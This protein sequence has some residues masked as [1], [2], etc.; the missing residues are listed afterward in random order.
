[1]R[2]ALVRYADRCPDDVDAV[3]LAR[4]IAASSPSAGR[5]I[6]IPWPLWQ[7]HG[8]NPAGR[9]LSMA[10]TFKLVAAV[11]ALAAVGWAIAGGPGPGPGPS[12]VDDPSPSPTSLVGEDWAFFSGTVTGEASSTD[13]DPGYED[14]GI[15]VTLGHGSQGDFL[16]TDDPRMNGT[17]TRTTNLFSQDGHGNLGRSLMTI[18]NDEGAWT[19]PMTFIHQ[20]TS[21]NP[22]NEIEQWAGWCE[23]SGAYTGLKAYVAWAY[24]GHGVYGFISSGDG[25][26]MPEA[27][28]S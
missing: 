19:C 16:M 25:P 13:P 9:T 21:R 10:G 7:S 18:T 24:P 3:A 5:D 14:N 12:Q 27:P 2:R 22:E 1:L 6:S 15:L 28:A 11:A 23:G 4:E 26:P 20:P 8:T 17:R